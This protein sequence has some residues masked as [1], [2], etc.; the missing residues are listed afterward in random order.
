M[1]DKRNKQ[2]LY[3]RLIEEEDEDFSLTKIIL[4]MTALILSSMTIFMIIYLIPLLYHAWR[5]ITF[6]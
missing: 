5:F 6:F 2:K 3:I 1:L 4:T